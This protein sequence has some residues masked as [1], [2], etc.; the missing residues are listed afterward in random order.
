MGF[1]FSRKVRCGIFLLLGGEMWDLPSFGTFQNTAMLHFDHWGRG[2]I[3]LFHTGIPI[4]LVVF[5]VDLIGS[6]MQPYGHLDA[7]RL[8]PVC[9]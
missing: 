8:V 5:Q 9:I 1:T 2:N 4:R 6:S 3:S 7:D